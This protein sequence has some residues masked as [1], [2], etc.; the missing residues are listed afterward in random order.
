M[1]YAL[2]FRVKSGHAIAVALAGP[3][4][5]PAPL[6]R[7]IVALSDPR[8]RGTTQP[9]HAGFGAAQQ[10]VRTIA[11]LAAIIE[12]CARR[13]TG[14]LLNDV[15]LAGHVCTGAALVVGSVIDPAAVGNP[16]IRAHA[17]EG[18][19]FRTVLEEALRA[20]HVEC[21]VIVEGALQAE[22][23]KTLQRDASAINEVVG[24]FGRAFGRPWRAT[25]KA[26][27]MAA[28]IALG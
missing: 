12:H 26:A 15:R 21:A 22:A 3:R 27:A 7:T 11:R 9:Y 5:T 24:G 4:A 17:H 23:A 1:T 20:N 25:E 18:R 19:L 6:V 16:H 13:S 2:G 14:E 28:W 8:V 10:D